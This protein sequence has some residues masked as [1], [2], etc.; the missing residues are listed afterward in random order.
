[1]TREVLDHLDQKLLPPVGDA[2]PTKVMERKRIDRRVPTHHLNIWNQIVYHPTVRFPIAFRASVEDMTQP[3]LADKHCL[4]ATT[5]LQ[6]IGL[7]TR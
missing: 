4:P 3:G 5:V 6:E 1:M 7:C 2:P